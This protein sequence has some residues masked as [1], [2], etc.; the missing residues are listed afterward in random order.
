MRK[1]QVWELSRLCPETSTKLY[2]HELGFCSVPIVQIYWTGGSDL[3]TSLSLYL[4]RV[5]L[6]MAKEREEHCTEITI[7]VFPEMKLH[8]L[9]SHSAFMFLWAI[10]I[11]PGSVC[12]FGCSKIGRP[13][14]GIYKSLTDKWMWTLETEHYNYVLD[15]MRPHRFISGN[16]KYKIFLLD[17][18]RPFICSYW[19][20]AISH[21]C[22]DTPR[23]MRLRNDLVRRGSGRRSLG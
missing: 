2:V 8:G 20:T 15:I 12:L 22:C 18:Y 5:S 21:L 4:L 23:R 16:T 7:H 10:Y 17:S 6:V 14:L 9:V 13:I 11:F 19:P 3:S 1:P